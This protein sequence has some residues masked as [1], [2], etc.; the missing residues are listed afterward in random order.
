MNNNFDFSSFTLATG[1]KFS[2]NSKKMFKTKKDEA[3]I[4]SLAEKMLYGKSA[5]IPDYPV[6]LEAIVDEKNNFV[7]SFV[8]KDLKVPYDNSSE[9]SPIILDIYG[10]ISGDPEPMALAKNLQKIVCPLPFLKTV[11]LTPK[12]VLYSADVIIPF[13]ALISGCNFLSSGM[14]GQYSKAL[15][16][17]V[18]DILL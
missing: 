18:M 17:A 12:D 11:T 15:T 6:Y 3:F 9:K 10:S 2:Y 1:K 4:Y 7:I 14:S 16:C 5:K 13:V 8:L